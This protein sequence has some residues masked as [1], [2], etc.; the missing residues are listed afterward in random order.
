MLLVCTV[1]ELLGEVLNIMNNPK[2]LQTLVNLPRGSAEKELMGLLP[3]YYVYHYME[4][5]NSWASLGPQATD[6]KAD[7]KIKMKEGEIASLKGLC[8]EIRTAIIDRGGTAF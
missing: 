5:G 3:L 7:L 4:T 6:I 8:K 2:G 1:G